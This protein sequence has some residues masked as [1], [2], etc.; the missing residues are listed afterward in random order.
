M[1][2]TTRTKPSF[3]VHEIPTTKVAIIVKNG[4]INVAATQ[5]VEIYVHSYHDS[6]PPTP[7]IVGDTIDSQNTAWSLVDK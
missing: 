4:T 5:P 7:F 3:H 6:A 1:I 2:R